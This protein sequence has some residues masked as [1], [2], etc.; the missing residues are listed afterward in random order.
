MRFSNDGQS[1]KSN[2]VLTVTI[3]IRCDELGDILPSTSYDGTISIF[4]TLRMIFSFAMQ[5]LIAYD[6][7][8]R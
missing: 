6:R 2:I 8:I 7:C 3:F 1:V 5:S 4:A